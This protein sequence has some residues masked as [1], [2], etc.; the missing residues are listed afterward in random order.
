MSEK[1][2][3][4]HTAH[5]QVAAVE[6]EPRVVVGSFFNGLSVPRDTAFDLYQHS[7]QRDE[8]VL[9]GENATL[10]Y[11][12][13]TGGAAEHNDYVVAVYDPSLK[14]VELFKA[15]MVYGKVTALK[16]RVH[17]GPKIRLRGLLYASQRI[18]L[19]REF[20]T[21]KAKQAIDNVQKNSINLEALEVH[22]V[23]IVD[24]VEA[25]TRDLALAAEAEKL[26][27]A[28][29][30]TPA[31]NVGATNVEDV[32]PVSGLLPARE[33]AAVRVGPLTLASEAERL[34]M[35][36][37]ALPLLAQLMTQQV[38]ANSDTGVRLAYYA[39]LLVAL[40]KCRFVKSK[41]QLVEKLA[42]QPPG[43]LVDG[44][45]ARFTVPRTLARGQL[46]LQLFVVDPPSEDRL[47]CHLLIA[48][49]HLHRFE[50]EVS[51][52]CNELGL[53]PS[54]VV[55]LLRAVGATVKAMSSAQASARGYTR[56]AEHKVGVLRVP[57]S[58]PDMART[59]KS[60]RR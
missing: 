6:T 25:A 8:F 54:R 40:F 10:E 21:K 46:K 11:N 26:V 5:L 31:P 37:H 60:K 58:P 53:K 16:H 48:L 45:L 24:N 41:N 56:A 1:G 12:G 42:A 34:Q 36:P 38:H 43:V 50:V 35:L 7:E 14:L 27:N 30:L 17:K 9:H 3:T 52:V 19:G 2:H 18:A 28:L 51:A 20:G 49:L 23:D 59:F 39:L 55:G 15:P 33:L 32:Y 47:L 22:E 13:A 44:L 57:F 4:K 29:G